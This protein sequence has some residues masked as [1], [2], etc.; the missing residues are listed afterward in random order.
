VIADQSQLIQILTNLVLNSIQAMPNGGRLIVGTEG[1][2]NSTTL[3]VTDTG[4]GMSQEVQENMFTPFFTTKSDDQGTGL[5]LSVVHGIVSS[6]GGNIEVESAINRGTRV[7]VSL[8]VGEES[9][10]E[11]SESG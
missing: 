9:Q 8:P 5:G 7:T 6:L 11:S 4:N 10:E 1:G 2:E 3:S